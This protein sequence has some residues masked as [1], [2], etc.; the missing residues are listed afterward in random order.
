MRPSEEATSGTLA[1]PLPV[2]TGTLARSDSHASASCHA[3][4]RECLM[5]RH[6]TRATH[7]TSWHAS[8]SCHAMACAS[9]K[10][11]FNGFPWSTAGQMTRIV[12]GE[13]TH[14]KMSPMSI[15]KRVITRW[16]KNRNGIAT[17]ARLCGL[18]RWMDGGIE[19][20]GS[21]N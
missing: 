10:R 12:G 15:L 21:E 18:V 3:M 5:P 14:L 9:C 4:A 17:C 16:P 13:A 19:R 6:G 8:A 2:K 20:Y 11:P 1:A 7:D